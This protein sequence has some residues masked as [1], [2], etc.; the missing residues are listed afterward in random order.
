MDK[1][2]PTEYEVT[3]I[4]TEDRHGQGVRIVQ[5]G[6]KDWQKKLHDVVY[7]IGLD[8]SVFFTYVDG[9]RAELHVVEPE[10]GKLHLR[11]DKD[12]GT[13]NNL[14]SLPQCPTHLP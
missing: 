1:Q 9:Q 3:C 12:E 7:E 4:V 6:G 10:K 11:T 8:V 2:Q 14:L 5:I 13:T